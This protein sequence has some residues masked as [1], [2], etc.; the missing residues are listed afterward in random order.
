[1][2]VS[3]HSLVAI[4]LA[5]ILFKLLPESPRYLASRRER[6]SELIAMLR[7][8]GHNVPT[9]ATFVE[10]GAWLGGLP[11]VEGDG[12]AAAGASLDGLEVPPPSDLLPEA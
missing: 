10:A 2:L 9:D 4:A 8:L 6:W 7:K 12:V 1:M 3:R 5:L 11:P